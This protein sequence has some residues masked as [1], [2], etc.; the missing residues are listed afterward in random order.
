V[1]ATDFIFEVERALRQQLNYRAVTI[2]IS[3]A[4]RFPAAANI[5]D[6][7]PNT[8]AEHQSL[9]FAP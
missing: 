7:T 9:I 2:S 8:N 3:V 1:T 5:E 4:D 6:G